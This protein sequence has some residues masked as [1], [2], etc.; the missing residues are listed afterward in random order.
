MSKRCSIVGF[1]A[2]VVAWSAWAAPSALAAP[3]APERIDY[4]DDIRPILSD[5]C[6]ACHGPDEAQRQAGLRLDTEF[7]ALHEL[8]GGGHA[9]VRGEPGASVLLERV[10]SDDPVRRMPPAYMGHDPLSED[11]IAIL[12]TWIEQGAV[13]TGHWAFDPPRKTPVPDAGNGTQVRNAIDSLVLQRLEGE[14][15]TFTPPAELRTLARRAALDL[16]GLPLDPAA[17][18]A[19]AKD[20]SPEAYDALLNRLLSSPRYGEHLAAMW[21]DA[22][23]YA[24]TNGYQTDGIRSMWRWRDWVIGAFNRNVSFDRFTIEQLAGDMLPGATRDQVIASGFNRNHR[25]TAEGGSVNE[26]FRVEYVADRTETTATVWL[27]LTL[28]CARCHD[29]KFDPLSQKEYYQFFSYFNNVPEKGM[30]WN[31]GNE[32]P[33]VLAPTPPQETRLSLLEAAA[34]AAAER[35]DA[36]ADRA[37]TE[38]AEWERELAASPEPEWAPRQ[39]LAAHAGLD[40]R[41]RVASFSGGSIDGNSEPEP[42]AT[43]FVEGRIGGA[44]VFDGAKYA[45]LGK[46]GNFN[47]LDPVSVSAWILP[48]TAANG[49]IVSSMTE[50]PI[51]SGWGLFVRGGKLW[52]HMSQRWSDLSMRIETKRDIAAGKWQ[53]VL[54]TYDGKRKAKGVRMYIDGED[55]DLN[56]LFDN[57]DWPSKSNATLKIG[58]GGGLDNRFVGRIDEVRVYDRELRPAEARSLASTLNLAALAAI[59]TAQ[60]TRPQRDKLRQAFL[61]SGASRKVR[62]ALFASREARRRL[63]EFRSEI[64]TVMVMQEGARRQA[65]V[66]DR[67]RY[68]ARGEPVP[69]GIPESIRNGLAADAG[70]RLALARWVASRSNPLTARVIVNRFWQM[71]FG[72]GI[73]KTVDDFG[74]QGEA[75]SNQQLLDWLAVEFMDSGWDVKQLLKTIMSSATYRQSSRA[76]PALRERDPEN[77]LLARGPRFRLSAATIRDQALA[78]SGLLERTLGGPSVKPYQP[79]GLWKEVSGQVYEPGSGSDLYRRSLY[80]Y[81]K[82]T[83]APPSMMNF[84]A[85]D[86]EVC[87]VHVKR[88]NTPLQALNTMNDPTF[89]ESA[90]NLAESILQSNLGGHAQRIE[91]TF[92]SVLSRAPRPAESEVLETLLQSYIAEFGADPEAAEKLLEVG[93]SSWSPEMDPHELAAYTGIASLVLNL[94]E[95]VMKQ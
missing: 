78:A 5:R 94:D 62:R 90:R 95:A 28:A 81:W 85:S 51:G 79:P 53:H 45:D 12:R 50:N 20:S 61:D 35:W 83:V 32:D 70:D 58:G 84:D 36:M 31:F 57:L 9:V 77:R 6:Y 2:F 37:D 46:V 22:A 71:L 82:R 23:R 67:G 14:G 63:E 18:E 25:T 54:L 89:V 4:N 91:A 72:V 44:A 73:V 52:W 10:T 76:G 40:G 26:E 29:H 49:A 19:F 75:P 87:T 66:L 65:Y 3:R 41:L 33:L 69:P 8:A 11:E 88:T 74:S 16:T 24:D 59:P 92:R 21:L 93:D 48:E 80:T 17:V 64:P 34:S 38:Q 15:L 27:G 42:A 1:C 13:W 47:Y 7:G 86:R 60:R 55:Q 56:I 30:V 39:G 43:V 68:D